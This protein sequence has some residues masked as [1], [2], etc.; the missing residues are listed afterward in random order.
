[1]RHLRR[2]SECRMPAGGGSGRTLQRWS[3]GRIPSQWEQARFCFGFWL[4]L[5]L[6]CSFETG[7]LYVVQSSV[8]VV[9]LLKLSTDW[10][11]EGLT[12]TREGKLLH[13]KSI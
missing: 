5:F 3:A 2:T 13:S 12:H 6:F 10:M 8:F 11:D 4:S 1:M 7:F 9:V